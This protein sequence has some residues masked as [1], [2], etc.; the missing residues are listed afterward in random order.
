MFAARAASGHAAAPPS[1]VMNW[2]RCN[3]AIIRSPRR[4]WRAVSA[5]GGGRAAWPSLR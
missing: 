3:F 2:R 5:V 1:N 4:R